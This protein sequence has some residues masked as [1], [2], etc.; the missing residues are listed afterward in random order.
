MAKQ[1]IFSEDARRKLQKGVDTVANAVI[2][3]L[4][5]KGRNVGLERSSA[6]PRSHM[7]V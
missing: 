4:G 3:T 5:P 2:T 7:T 6:A 1:L